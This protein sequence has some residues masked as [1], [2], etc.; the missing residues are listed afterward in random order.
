MLIFGFP[1]EIWL[2]VFA[3]VLV[4]VKS[5]VTLGWGGAITTTLVSTISGMILH[6][7]FLS[8]TGLHQDWGILVAILIALTAENLMKGVL[9]WS[10]EKGA[11]K[12]LL[13]A[14]I[15]RDPS[16]LIDKDEK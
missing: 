9:D 15:G 7:P 4:R 5:S 1:I 3:A 6:R 14:V 10:S 8:L 12:N 16:K 13:R 2:G 11:L